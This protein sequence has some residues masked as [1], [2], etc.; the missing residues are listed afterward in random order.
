MAA[1]VSDGLPEKNP[2]VPPLP[3]PLSPEWRADRNGG[4][5]RRRSRV[6]VPSLAFCRLQ[7]FGC[8]RHQGRAVLVHCPNGILAFRSAERERPARSAGGS[9]RSHLRHRRTRR[10]HC[11]VSGLVGEG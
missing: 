4:L 10:P 11:P 1:L 5:S 3:P 9:T 7:S 2:H 6:R 8:L